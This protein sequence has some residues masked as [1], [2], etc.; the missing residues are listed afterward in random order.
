VEGLWRRDAVGQRQSN[1][2]LP[3]CT[4][5]EGAQRGG[6]PRRIGICEPEGPYTRGDEYLC[7][8]NRKYDAE[9]GV[10]CT[11]TLDPSILASGMYLRAP[12]AQSKPYPLTSRLPQTTFKYLAHAS[13][14]TALDMLGQVP[15]NKSLRYVHFFHSFA[16][17]TGY[18]V[19]E[20]FQPME[21]LQ[22]VILEG[23]REKDVE[24]MVEH[25]SGPAYS[26][27]LAKVV[28]VETK[29]VA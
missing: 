9:A 6:V 26:D 10:R 14:K 12:K 21:R 3:E 23:G 2:R 7:T 18:A 15:F 20:Q 11:R 19:V 4:V 16:K 8:S 5:D 29:L 1:R 25:L 13:S 28:F 24:E 17:S 27:L 22:A